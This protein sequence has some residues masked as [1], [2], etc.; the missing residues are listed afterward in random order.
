[1]GKEIKTLIGTVLD[2]KKNCACGD[3][4][5]GF[6]SICKTIAKDIIIMKVQSEWIINERELKEVVLV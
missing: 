6:C 3:T 2:R 1:M 4:E 5:E